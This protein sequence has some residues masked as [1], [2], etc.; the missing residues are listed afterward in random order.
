MIKNSS[1]EGFTIC[2][3]TITKTRPSSN[4][5]SS[6]R[7]IPKYTSRASQTWWIDSINVKNSS[8]TKKLNASSRK[9]KTSPS[10]HKKALKSSLTFKISKKSPITATSY[11]TSLKTKANFLMNKPINLFSGKTSATKSIKPSKTKPY[12]PLTLKRNPSL[13]SLN[14]NN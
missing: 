2:K 13:I 9:N 8:S 12:H 3:N 6:I 4:T 11:A 5:T 7:I 1:W 14:K 10:P